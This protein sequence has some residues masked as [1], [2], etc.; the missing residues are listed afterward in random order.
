MAERRS[1]RLLA[2]APDAMAVDSPTTK[3]DGRVEA[4]KTNATALAAARAAKAVEFARVQA[5]R[6]QSLK[7]ARA[8]L[9]EQHMLEN[10]RLRQLKRARLSPEEEKKVKA[11]EALAEDLPEGIRGAVIPVSTQLSAVRAVLTTWTDDGEPVLGSGQTAAKSMEERCSR[12]ATMYH[13]SPSFVKKAVNHYLANYKPM[14]RSFRQ[15]EKVDPAIARAVS[16]AITAF[17][18]G[19]AAAVTAHG[20]AEIVLEKV[21]IPI[22]ER[23]VRII[24]NNLDF[25]YHHHLK[26]A[27]DETVINNR[28]L[29]D[30][31]HRLIYVAK[32]EKIL[33][34]KKEGKAVLGWQDESFAHLTLA[35]E[36]SWAGLDG[37]VQ[38]LPTTKGRLLTISHVVTE[39]GLLVGHDDKGARLEP[40]LNSF[41]SA[42]TAEL[43]L[44]PT[45]VKADYHTYNACSFID[46]LKNRFLPAAKAAYPE[47][48]G[49]AATKVF[50]LH[51]DNAPT[52]HAVNKANIVDFKSMNKG[53]IVDYLRAN[54]VKSITYF[55]LVDN[56]EA[57]FTMKINEDLK[58]S[59]TTDN[60]E[61][62][63]EAAT[64][65]L[66]EHQQEQT[67]CAAEALAAA[68]GFVL[69]WG[70]P[71]NPEWNPIEMVW[72][73]MK[74][75]VAVLYKEGRTQAELLSQLRE[76]LYSTDFAAPGRLR[77]KGGG[78][79][80]DEPDG[81]CSS[82]KDLIRHCID[83]MNEWIA[84]VAGTTYTD[85]A[86]GE[87]VPW[88]QGKLGDG[89]LVIWKDALD[90]AE[91][92]KTRKALLHFIKLRVR[93]DEKFA[94]MQEEDGADDDMLVA[95]PLEQDPDDDDDD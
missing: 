84:S 95:F 35:V 48:F 49:P 32:L 46:W 80:P 11:L 36:A 50:Y 34:L 26:P 15:P 12:V 37:R 82:A 1:A 64:Q 93:Y 81:T 16:D 33:Q 44:S 85:P 5:A 52:H 13:L 23:K 2:A 51:I 86:T 18:Q 17:V 10:K 92:C 21:G 29:C 55:K 24:A 19:K 88:I 61:E 70:V 14:K 69:L 45:S 66:M 42:A 56:K 77:T 20:L 57:V 58:K 43:I 30:F 3:S 74:A 53:A 75:Y 73:V 59:S 6:T 9:H 89:L 27:T 76:A 7:R 39:D 83:K 71:R 78:Y 63:K 65:W 72:S 31:W 60:L 62:L 41:E 54:K 87:Q 91:K 22:T 28:T 4:A 25:K 79:V 68:E 90:V 8:V 40:P 47:C 38:G 94:N 67:R